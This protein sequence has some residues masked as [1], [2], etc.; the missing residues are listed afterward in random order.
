MVLKHVLICFRFRPPSFE[1]KASEDTIID[2]DTGSTVIFD[3]KVTA[4]RD[5]TVSNIFVIDFVRGIFL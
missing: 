4:L 3:C 2:A 5:K 1:E